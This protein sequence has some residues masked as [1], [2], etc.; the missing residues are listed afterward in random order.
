MKVVLT[1]AGTDPSGAAGIQA[2]LQTIRDHGHHGASVVTA[3][4]A[5]NTAGVHAVMRMPAELV[6]AQLDAVF[7]DLDI[8]AVKV[9]LVPDD[10][11]VA[12]IA[13]RVAHLPTVWDPVMANGDG[14]TRLFGGTIGALH[15]VFEPVIVTPNVPEIALL[16]GAEVADRASAHEA[17]A[18][19]ANRAGAVLLK[20]GHLPHD[21][22]VSDIWANRGE[23]HDLEPLPAVA[24]EVRG[25]GCQLSAAMACGLAEGL[26]P[27][28]AAER[29]R[30]YLNKLL[31]SRAQHIGKGRRVVVR[32]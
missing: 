32:V 8:A 9:G 25:T 5:Q 3:V 12:L 24:E 13:H 10:E 17:A 6:A 23:T 21:G 29:A 11:L 16:V 27:L 22:M 18:T 4:I 31:H 30:R 2:D 15:G 14:N 1:V 28:E 26:V 19:L 20:M 7:E